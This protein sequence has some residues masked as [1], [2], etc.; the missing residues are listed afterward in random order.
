[1]KNFPLNIINKQY[2]TIND[3]IKDYYTKIKYSNIEIK[4]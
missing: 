2:I 3:I 1:M 4:I